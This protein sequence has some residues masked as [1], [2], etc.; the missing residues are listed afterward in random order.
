MR[1]S[2]LRLCQDVLVSLAAFDSFEFD[3]DNETITIGAGQVWGEVDR[4]MEEFAPGYASTAPFILS[5]DGSCSA[6]V[7]LSVHDALTSELAVPS[8]RVVSPGCPPN[9][10]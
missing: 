6:P 7:Q 10:A 9:M 3:P 5:Q 1:R 8:S 2:W 4:K